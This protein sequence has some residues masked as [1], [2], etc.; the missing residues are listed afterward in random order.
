LALVSFA[1]SEPSRAAD[2]RD[3]F[4]SS[5]YT[6]CDAKLVGE[7]YGRDPWDAKA[8]IGQ[9]ILNGIGNNVPVILQESRA[10]GHRC[11]W[12][13]TGYTYD[14]AVALARIWHLGDPDAAKASVA[15][16]VTHGRGDVVQ[17]ALGRTGNQP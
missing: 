17:R 8:I 5:N 4:S 14:D 11:D 10:A 7:L 3:V 12:D 15:E 9:K 6:Y 13:D 16:F 1:T 2:A